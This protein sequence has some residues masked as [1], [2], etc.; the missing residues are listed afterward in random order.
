MIEMSEFAAIAEYYGN[1][2]NLFRLSFRME[3]NKYTFPMWIR[4]Q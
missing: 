1:D 4:I 2:K 3:T